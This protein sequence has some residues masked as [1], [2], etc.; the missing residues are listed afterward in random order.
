MRAKEGS[1]GGRRDRVYI[2]KSV[3]QRVPLRVLCSDAI[4]QSFKL[5]LLQRTI[6]VNEICNRQEP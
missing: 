3:T 5:M 1:V 6:V 2:Y 4:E